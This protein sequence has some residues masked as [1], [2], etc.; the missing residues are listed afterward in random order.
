MNAVVFAG[1]TPLP[2]DLGAGFDVRPPARRGDVYL[3]AKDGAAAIGLVDGYFDRVDAVAHK[4]VLWAMSRGVH[5]FGAASMGALRAAELEA[6]GMEGVGAIFEQLVRGEIED[7]DEVAIVH[8]EAE[9]GFRAL[10]EAMVNVRATLAAATA[11]GAIGEA[12]RAL[13][14]D[15]AKSLFYADR[16][17]PLI[18]A[19][20]ESRGAPRAELEALCAFLPTGKVDQ[21][22]RDARA[23]VRRMREHRAA[24]PGPKTVTYFFSRTDA[25]D[26]LCQTA[27]VARAQR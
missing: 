10:S 27:D 6:F 4:E 21:K 1:P 5:V 20:A 8:A 13:L 9:D 14:V 12:A 26:T 15:A 3:A 18:V 17:Y 22:A 7:D 25:W 11:A 19:L 23:L 24:L 2:A 16:A